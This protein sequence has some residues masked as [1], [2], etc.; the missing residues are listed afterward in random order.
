MPAVV[1]R[2]V[3]SFS[4]ISDFPEISAWPFPLKKSMY[5]RLRSLP[6]MPPKVRGGEGDVNGSREN[7][8]KVFPYADKNENPRRD[9]ALEA[10]GRSCHRKL[11]DDLPRLG[12]DL[13]LYPP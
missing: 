11:C 7:G 2:T 12:V 5:A 3:G 9:P 1:K 8:R 10:P 6:V 13:L 4:G